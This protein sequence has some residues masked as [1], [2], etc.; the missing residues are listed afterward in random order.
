MEPIVVK[1]DPRSQER[2]KKIIIK[3]DRSLDILSSR[4]FEN[5][6]VFWTP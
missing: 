1:D 4:I 3:G 5:F 2:S 6:K